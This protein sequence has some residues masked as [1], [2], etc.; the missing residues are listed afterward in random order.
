MDL[1]CPL[2]LGN[3]RQHVPICAKRIS[4]WVKESFKYC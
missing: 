2:F 1:G 3:N 4:S